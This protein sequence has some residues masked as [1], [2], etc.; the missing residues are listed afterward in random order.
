MA[1]SRMLSRSISI[2]KELNNL[3]LKSQFIYTWC[4]P[5]LD[6][7]GLIT[8]DPDKIKYM[9]FPR[10]YQ[11]TEE[12]IAIFVD[13]VVDK[14]I[15]KLDDCL[16]F[17]GFEKHNHITSYKKAKSEFKPN[18]YNQPKNEDSQ[19]SPE[20][21]SAP[22]SSRSKDRLGKDR[23]NSDCIPLEKQIEPYASQYAPS[24]IEKFLLHWSEKDKRGKERWQKEKTWEISKRLARWKMQ[25]EQWNYE[26]NARQ[27][28]VEEKPVHRDPINEWADT[29]FQK[30]DFSKY[31]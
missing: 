30:I 21:P 4:I 26:R 11:I 31:Q 10:N 27:V 14:L 23:L 18:R 29:G 28:K 24:M 17:K 2:D 19:E 25:D 8:N 12:D 1:K 15:E 6:D 7:Y 5:F 13:E 3:S 20:T 9:V 22:Q 16:Y